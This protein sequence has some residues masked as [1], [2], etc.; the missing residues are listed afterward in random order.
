MDI[1]DIKQECA[2]EDSHWIHPKRMIWTPAGSMTPLRYVYTLTTGEPSGYVQRWCGVKA[3][4]NPEHIYCQQDLCNQGLRFCTLCR[5]TK[6]LDSFG[7]SDSQQGRKTRCKACCNKRQR[8]RYTEEP[9][10]FAQ[11][12]KKWGEKNRKKRNHMTARYRAR[13]RG[14]SGTH[15][16]EEWELKKLS[17]GYRCANP[18]CR[19][20]EF[21]SVLKWGKRLSVDHILP[22][23]RPDLGATDEIYGVQ[24]LCMSCNAKKQ[25]LTAVDYRV[26]VEVPLEDTRQ[27]KTA[28]ESELR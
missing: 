19:M 10:V 6:T 15:S 11:R 20:T 3:C 12:A 27:Q 26:G 25:H 9:E 1:N 8:E 4:C 17:F 14:A 28:L 22:V 21:E 23:S 16:L 2:L 13:R 24:P 5:E 7:V 18:Q